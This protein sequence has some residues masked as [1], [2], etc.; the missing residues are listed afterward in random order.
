[1]DDFTWKVSL[2]FSSRIR[3]VEFDFP[4]ALGLNFERDK[5]TKVTIQC[6]TNHLRQLFQKPRNEKTFDITSI[7]LVKD[8][9]PINIYFHP[10]WTSFRSDFWRKHAVPEDRDSEPPLRAISTL[11]DRLQSLSDLLICGISLVFGL[12]GEVWVRSPDNNGRCDQE[13]I[14]KLMEQARVAHTEDSVTSERPAGDIVLSISN[15]VEPRFCINRDP[16]GH[17]WQMSDFT[18]EDDFGHRRLRALRDHPAAVQF[19][20]ATQRHSDRR[21]SR[22]FEL[23]RLLA[24]SMLLLPALRIWSHVFHQSQ[25][26]QTSARALALVVQLLLETD[27]SEG[28][29]TALLQEI[30]VPFDGIEFRDKMYFLSGGLEPDVDRAVRWLVPPRYL[31]QVFRLDESP[32]DSVHALLS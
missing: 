7:E 20:S 4:T 10:S 30:G 14:K 11:C 8:S 2:A 28:L 12:E 1:M 31:S 6:A 32:M 27:F 3:N 9:G 22:D 16:Y 18:D 24:G 26:I 29:W 15:E 13:I 17:P 25:R 5:G 23:C 21:M 19:E